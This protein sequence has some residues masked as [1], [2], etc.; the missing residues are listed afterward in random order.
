MPCSVYLEHTPEVDFNLD[1]N[2]F[3]PP[4]DGDD[5]DLTSPPLPGRERLPSREQES[6]QDRVLRTSCDI[7]VRRESKKKYVRKQ[8]KFN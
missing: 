1:E 5:F 8:D 2:D 3:R 4:S 6:F 7:S